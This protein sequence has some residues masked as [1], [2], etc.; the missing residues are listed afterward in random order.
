M[1]LIPRPLLDERNLFDNVR[2][3]PLPAE[4][5]AKPEFA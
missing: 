3:G 5:Q 2:V 4:A 1:K